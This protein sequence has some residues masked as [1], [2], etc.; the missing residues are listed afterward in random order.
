MMG[1]PTQIPVRAARVID[2]MWFWFGS[3]TVWVEAFKSRHI[4][5]GQ[6]HSGALACPKIQVR[7]VTPQTK[8]GPFRLLM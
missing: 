6:T 5:G 1:K 2:P 8:V 7:R 3:E 4:V